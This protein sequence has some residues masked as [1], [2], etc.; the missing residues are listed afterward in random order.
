[1]VRVGGWDVGITRAVDVSGIYLQGIDS[2]EI[3]ETVHGRGATAIAPYCVGVGYA[4]LIC[5]GVISPDS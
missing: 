1:V 5:P 2:S 4:V 3:V